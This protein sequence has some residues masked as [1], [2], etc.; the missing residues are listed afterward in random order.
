[1]KNYDIYLYKMSLWKTP[2]SDQS[3]NFRNRFDRGYLDDR[4]SGS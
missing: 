3:Q 2:E 4:S 1:M